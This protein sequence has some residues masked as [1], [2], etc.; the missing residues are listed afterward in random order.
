MLDFHKV[1]IFFYQ[2][3][4]S[5]TL[6]I[7]RTAREDRGPFFIPLYHFHR[8]RTFRHLFATLHVRHYNIFLI[9]MLVFTRLLLDEIYHLIELLFD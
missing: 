5:R 4:L 2:D 9:A 8:S 1:Y 7:H 6:T 3:F